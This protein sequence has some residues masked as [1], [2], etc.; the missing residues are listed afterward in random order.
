MITRAPIHR[1]TTIDVVDAWVF[2][3]GRAKLQCV[4]EATLKLFDQ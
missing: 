3:A 1:S 2:F 4:T